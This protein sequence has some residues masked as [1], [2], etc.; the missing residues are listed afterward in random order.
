MR[1]KL[2]PYL[3]I[4]GGKTEMNIYSW[5]KLKTETENQTNERKLC[6]NSV[7][8]I[9]TE[10]GKNVLSATAGKH[11]ECDPLEYDF[12]FGQPTDLT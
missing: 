9:L 12:V 2:G 11:C 10:N 4:S 3:S 7:W 5:L 8:G 6:D 1:N